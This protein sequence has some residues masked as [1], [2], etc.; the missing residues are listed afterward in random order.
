MEHFIDDLSKQ[1]AKGV[2]RRNMLSA[3][4]R[5]LFGA[6]VTSTWVGRLW[7]GS[8]STVAG[9][10]DSPSC[11]AVQ[12][13]VQLAFPDPTKFKNHGAYVSSVAHSVSAAQNADLVATS[14]SDCIISQFAQGV[15]TTDQ[16]SCGSIAMPS[17][18]CTQTDVT[19]P[20]IQTAA[21]LAL[22]AAP[23][24]WSDGTQ[25]QLAIKLTEEIIGCVFSGGTGGSQSTENRSQ[26]ILSASNLSSST[27]MTP[28][29]N[30]CGPNNSLDHS[31]LLP[32]ATCLNTQ[33]YQ[34]DNCY[35]EYCVA[36]LCDFTL[37][38]AQCDNPLLATC[39]GQGG[40]SQAALTDSNTSVICGW[41]KCLMG[42]IGLPTLEAVIC[43]ELR[44]TRT[45]L[46]PLCALPVSQCLPDC[47]ATGKGE[48]C[49]DTCCPC[50]QSCANGSC[51]CAPG[52]TFCEGGDT[53]T[54]CPAGT[55]CSDGSCVTC[56]E[57]TTACG[58]TCCPSGETC[59]G[60]TCC[61][62]GQV[63]SSGQ[64]GCAS[65]AEV[66]GTTCCPPPGICLNGSC[67]TNACGGNEYV[68]CLSGL[69]T[70]SCCLVSSQQICCKS[71]VS[72][73][74]CDSGSSCCAAAAGILT[75]CPPNTVCCNAVGPN[76]GPF[77]CSTADPICVYVAQGGPGCTQ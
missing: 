17:E 9:G 29:V 74:C 19:A 16:Q 39:L 62:S 54:C 69:G 6:F 3:T 43:A 52:Q 53:S 33:C 77:C 5:A 76:E 27:C 40:C 15:S 1:L 59:C 68:P 61:A 21:I 25:F 31:Y 44:L 49:G 10:V 66:C 72:S 48:A 70:L 37:Q 67:S 22:G 56:P 71:A 57:G 64:C 13:S 12:K 34:H 28:A 30:Y 46:E 55:I 8:T 36:D 11:G 73:T 60:T 45:F 58:T 42:G 38:T 7:A 32:V 23:N 4:S 51:T 50:G 14:C 63:C 20:Q 35:G 18:S 65:Q 2:S 41:V 24:A 47:S 26:A 75:C